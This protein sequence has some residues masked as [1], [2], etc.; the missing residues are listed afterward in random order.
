MDHVLHERIRRD[1]LAAL[2]PL[3]GTRPLDPAEWLLTDEAHA[4]QMA[5]RDRLIRE[6]RG[7]VIALDDAATPAAAELLETVLES[8]IGRPGYVLGEVVRRPDG[9]A[10]PCDRADPMATLGRLVQEDL[11]LLEKRGDEHVLTGA[12]LCFPSRWMLAEKFRR[13]L[14]RIHEPVAPYDDN[15][16]RRVQRLFDGVKPGRPLWR[17]NLVPHHDPSLFQPV[18]ETAKVRA[19][20]A[21]APYLRSERQCILRLPRTGA[22]VFSIH[23]TLVRAE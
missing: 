4:G 13:P 9:V 5:L 10:V 6:H 14:V 21:D 12:V 11:C 22:V 20:A 8:L 7:E 23:T 17:V 18:S 1:S 16:A 3:P 15:V 19:E 2:G